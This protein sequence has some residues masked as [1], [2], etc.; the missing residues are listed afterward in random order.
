[1]TTKHA[2]LDTNTFLHFRSFEQIHWPV[3]LNCDQAT[4]VL[5]PVILSELDK[6][7]YDSSGKIRERARAP[8][9]VLVPAQSAG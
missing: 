3:V 1:M 4:L 5:A 6:K 2:F 7:K 8:L 9:L